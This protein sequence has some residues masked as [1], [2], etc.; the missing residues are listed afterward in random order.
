VSAYK[1]SKAWHIGHDLAI[2]IHKTVRDMPGG[3][4]SELAVHMRRSAATAPLKLAESIELSARHEK[5][6]CYQAARDALVDL[7]QH[8]SLAYDV[9]YIERQ[10]HDELA[11]KA[12]AAHQLLNT[13][14]R[15]TRQDTTTAVD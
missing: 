9:H 11:G 4:S 6:A 2:A 5:L 8:L 12:I 3:D 1:I 14:I 13:L 15:K 7:Q 10:L